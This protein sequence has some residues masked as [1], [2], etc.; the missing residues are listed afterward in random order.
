[1]TGI[2]LRA[3]GD[4]VLLDVYAAPR[5]AKSRLAGHHGGRLKVQVAAPPVDGAANAELARFLARELGVPRSAVRL[6][7]GASDRRKT[8]AIEGLD[9]AAARTRLGL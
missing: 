3:D 4:R 5:A 6:V 2:P 8:L 1:M 7:R 9:L